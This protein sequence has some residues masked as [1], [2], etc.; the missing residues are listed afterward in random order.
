MD[1]CHQELDSLCKCDVYDLV[2]PLQGRRI[3]NNCWVFDRKTDGWKR[4][5]LVAKGFSQVEGIDYDDIFSPVVRYES[6]CPMVALAAS[7]QWH[8]SS[9]DV[10]TAF[11]YGELG[12]E[13]FMEQ[14]E[15]FKKKGQEYKVFCLKKALYELKQAALQWWQALDKSMEAMGFKHLKADSGVFVLICSGWS[16]VIVIVY[17]DD[18]VFIGPQKHLVN[19]YKEHFMCYRPWERQAAIDCRASCKFGLTGAMGT[20]FVLEQQDRP[21]LW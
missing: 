4:A 15:G 9:I 11:L 2:I 16:E 5:C 7:Q 8:M 6:V 3:I 13:L 14:P 18:A 20:V 10:K 19:T 17:V 1:A 21:A 12:E